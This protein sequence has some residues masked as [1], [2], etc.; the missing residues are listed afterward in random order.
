MLAILGLSP[1][2]MNFRNILMVPIKELELPVIE[3]IFKIICHR[4]VFKCEHNYV[5]TIFIYLVEGIINKYLL[6]EIPNYAI[7]NGVVSGA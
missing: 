7:Q 4:N 3:K 2:H 6:V 5:S 1:L